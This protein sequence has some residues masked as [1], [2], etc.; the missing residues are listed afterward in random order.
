MQKTFF[1]YLSFILVSIIVLLLSFMIGSVHLDLMHLNSTAESILIYYRI[2][3]SLECFLVGGMLGL[4]GSI[5]QVILRNPLADGFTTGI[6]S[7]SALGAVLAISLG[8]SY[9]FVSFFAFAFGIAGMVLVLYIAKLQDIEDYTILILAG[10]VL[11]IVA[12]S[13][14]SFI[15]Y[16]FEDSIGSIVFWLMGG[17]YNVG[18]NKAAVLS[19]V[20][21]IAL[22]VFIKMSMELGVLSFDGLSSASMGLN[23]GFTKG[24]AY[25][26]SSILVA[27]AVSIS[28]II[29]FVGLITPHISRALFG[30]NM[31]LNIISSSF[32][33]ANLL[34]VSD[35][36][37]RVILSSGEELPV[38]VLTSMI[39]GIFFMWLLIKK[40][41]TIW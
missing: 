19:I 21:F 35:L 32:L 26:L 29:P 23:I 12:A 3:R 22:V 28:G 4:S 25:L 40:R 11:N 24:S 1:I 13:F 14:I 38:G 16:L 37:S 2:P 8:L 17:F 6:A 7:S 34:L 30:H 27:F 41:K 31:K 15:K 10:I 5:F 36:L 18:Y 9:A 33:G 39:G 20:F